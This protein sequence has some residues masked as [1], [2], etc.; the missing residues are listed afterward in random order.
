MAT[1][2]CRAGDACANAHHCEA[3]N[4][5]PRDFRGEFRP[6]V[7]V[8]AMIT[9]VLRRVTDAASSQRLL[10]A[11]TAGQRAAADFRRAAPAPSGST[12]MRGNHVALQRNAAM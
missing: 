2:A 5:V 9:G 7:L 3:G 11:A 12:G 6:R 4:R 8:A 10:A 1:H